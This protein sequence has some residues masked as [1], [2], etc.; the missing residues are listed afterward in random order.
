MISW[1]LV[2]RGLSHVD[3]SGKAKMVSVA[4]KSVTSRIAIA[5]SIISMKAETV[6]AIR[7]NNNKKGDVLAVARI[8]GVQVKSISNIIECLYK[9]V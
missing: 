9:I 5:Q 3:G 8:A 1:K 2:S 7:D 4:H 6:Q